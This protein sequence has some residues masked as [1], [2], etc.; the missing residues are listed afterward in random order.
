MYLV[1]SSAQNV[2]CGIE[3]GS[4]ATMKPAAPGAGSEI[5]EGDNPYASFVAAA[6]VRAEALAA[7]S[8][9]PFSVQPA[10]VQIPAF[11]KVPVKLIYTPVHPSPRKGFS[12]KLETGTDL[13]NYTAVIEVHGEAKRVSRLPLK[14]KC[15]YNVAEVSPTSLEFQDDFK[16]QIC[17]QQFCVKNRAKALSMRYH[18][19]KLPPF[20]HVHPRQGTVP[21]GA[22]SALDV[23]YK[24]KALGAHDGKVQLSIH[25]EHGRLVEQHAIHVHGV[26]D[27]AHSVLPGKIIPVPDCPGKLASHKAQKNR[28]SFVPGLKHPKSQPKAAEDDFIVADAD[29]MYNG[30]PGLGRQDDAL[31][32]ATSNMPATYTPTKELS[33]ESIKR[34]HIHQVSVLMCFSTVRF[35]S[36]KQNTYRSAGDVEQGEWW[37]SSLREG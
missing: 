14:G 36:L 19:K 10:H 5:P 12:S 16:S 21:A 35:T 32:L 11:Q 30:D 33:P 26:C 17:Q 3:L 20:F 9:A 2:T 6:R 28:V 7:A 31:W 4:T 15:A 27:N 29:D 34:V 1:N 37:Q 13:H 23:F 18:V 8:K 24:P 22:T 25:T